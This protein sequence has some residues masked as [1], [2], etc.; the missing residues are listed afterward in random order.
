VIDLLSLL[1]D[2]VEIERVQLLRDH[3]DP[4]LPGDQTM[5]PHAECAIEFILRKR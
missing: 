1:T 5:T 3:F 2:V 4:L